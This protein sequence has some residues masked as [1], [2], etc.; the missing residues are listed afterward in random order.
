MSIRCVQITYSVGALGELR[1]SVYTDLE[2][3]DPLYDVRINE[4]AQ[5]VIQ[6]ELLDYG[7][8]RSYD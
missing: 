2:P 1:L 3:D 6:Q 8:V 5:Q 4:L 7:V